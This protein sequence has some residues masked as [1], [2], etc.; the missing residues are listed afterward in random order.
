M[1]DLKCTSRQT[2]PVVLCML[3]VFGCSGSSDVELSDSPET[4]SITTDSAMTDLVV[5]D[6]LVQN[7]TRVSFD[8]EVPVYQSDEL[9]VNLAWGDLNVRAAW[10]G[11]QFWSVSEE[12][13]TN[14]SNLLVVTFADR[15]GDITL[16]SFET[17]F[18]TGTN[19]AESFNIS[20]SQFNTA[21][22]D[23]DGDGISNLDQLLAGTAVSDEVR[24]LLFSETRDFRHDSIEDALIAVEE[25]T[26]SVGMQTIRA[27][28]SAGVFTDENLAN[29]HAVVWLSTSGDV[30]GDDEQ[31]AFERYIRAGGGYAGI[32][33]AS[34]TE[35]EWS[36]YGRLV[37]AYFERHPDIQ[38][39]IMDVEDA[40][41]PS[42]VHLG[43]QWIRTDEWYDFNINPRAQV[44]VL[45]SL[46]EASYN[47][48]GMGDDHPIAWFH[49]FDGGRSWYTGGGHSSESYSEPDF[50]LHLLG[51][52]RY[53]AGVDQ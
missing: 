35:F 23:D 38:S 7:N 1:F 14:T 33:A 37:G 34:F 28:D 46:D 6:P 43:E 39:A 5:P 24:I 25:L 8:I 49:E 48:G 26:A 51:G 19:A 41:H 40:A 27:A 16:A 22:W 47:G 4:N 13:P 20:N 45:L 10:L 42:T 53:A 36:W 44:N 3:F 9:Q 32:H 50:R 2:A 11:D 12:L 17:E 29:F 18:T 52:L 31:A 30:L 15:N 21:R